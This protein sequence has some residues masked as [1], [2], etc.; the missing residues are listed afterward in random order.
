MI[1]VQMNEEELRAM[2]REEVRNSLN[3]RI[4]NS[5]EQQNDDI[6]DINEAMQIIK[7]RKPTIYALTS[8]GKIP[9]FK[10]TK[11]LYFIKSEII[12]WLMER[13]KVFKK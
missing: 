9:F 10:R 12:N 7:L 5:T 1:I 13:R 8:K 6:L 2:V 4:S 11:N 3:E